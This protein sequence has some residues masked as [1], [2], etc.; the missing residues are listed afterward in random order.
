MNEGESAVR[1]I[2][3]KYI[4]EDIK[5]KQDGDD[6]VYSQKV[7]NINSVDDIKDIISCFDGD[8]IFRGQRDAFWALVPSIQRFTTSIDWDSYENAVVDAVMEKEQQCVKFKGAPYHEKLMNIQHYGGVTRF[9][10]FSFNWRV[11]T[12]FAFCGD[13]KESYKNSH[14][15]CAIWAV[16]YKKIKANAEKFMQ[17]KWG[18]IPKS[19]EEILSKMVTEDKIGSFVYPFVFSGNKSSRIVKQEGLL[20]AQCDPCDSFGNNLFNIW[21][22]R[23]LSRH[24]YETFELMVSKIIIPFSLR[25]D[26]LDFLGT[27][28]FTK[29]YLLPGKE[30]F[31]SMKKIIQDVDIQAQ[32]R[33]KKKIEEFKKG[34]E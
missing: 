20:L 1:N 33:I 21:E 16:N 17:E 4:L 3:S 2:A 29:E 26:V 24:D 7:G 5:I 10:D 25:K 30:E 34:M 9:L 15:F 11:A 28:G 12:F 22:E 13:Q 32:K 19:Q 31:S 27:E 18:Y 6:Y 23:E 8:W 14:E